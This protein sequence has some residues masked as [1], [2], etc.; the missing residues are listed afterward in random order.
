MKM[1]SKLFSFSAKMALAILA[2]GTVFASCYD[3]ENGDVTKPYVAPDAMYTFV[4]TVTNHIT[5]A[6]VANASVALSG[7]IEGTATADENGVY[8]IVKAVNGGTSGAVTITVAGT[9][10]YDSKTAT[11]S[12]E[13]IA[14]GQAVTYYKDIVVNYTEFI[15]EGMTVSSSVKTESE[16]LQLSGEPEADH[17]SVELDIMNKSDEPLFI[18]RTFTVKKGVVVDP[19]SENNIY[20]FTQTK[21]TDD[22]IAWI[23]NYIKADLGAEPTKDFETENVAY[24]ILI[25]PQTALKNVTVSYL[26]EYKTYMFSYDGNDYTVTAKRVVKVTFANEQT[27]FAHY[28]GHGHGHGNGDNAGGGIINA[29]L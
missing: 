17:Y 1:K 3:S 2:V 19:D 28:H 23:K 27:T 26:Y 14:N 12:I 20:S 15:E 25:A 11:V 7:A 9:A 24:N 6:P 21:S 4:G 29:D 18:T 16:D 8:Q 5:G 13:K 22:V 10:S